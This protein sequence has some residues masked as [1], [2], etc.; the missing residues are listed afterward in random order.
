PGGPEPEPHG[1]T[2]DPHPVVLPQHDRH[3]LA[4]PPAAGEPE[5]ARGEGQHP[6]DDHRRPNMGTRPPRP[7]PPEDGGHPV[8]LEP[9][10]PPTDRAER[11]VQDGTDRGP[12]VAGVEQ[13]KYVGTEAN[14]GVCGPAVVPEQGPPGSPGKAPT[15]TTP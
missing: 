6:L 3:R 8:G 11:T 12:R 4:T 13:Q 7:G 1:L 9:L 15:P 2:A 5:V 10:L 14:I